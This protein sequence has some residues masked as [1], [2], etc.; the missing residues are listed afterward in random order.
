MVGLVRHRRTKGPATDRPY[1]NHRATPRL[2]QCEVILY[3]SANATYRDL[4]GSWNGAGK[5]S[6]WWI[7]DKAVNAHAR[8]EVCLS[9]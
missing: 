1:L 8:R 2:H 7:G 3:M 6:V 9:S 5:G 4:G